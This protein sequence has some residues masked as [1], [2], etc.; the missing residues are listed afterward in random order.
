MNAKTKIVV[1]YMYLSLGVIGHWTLLY[2]WANNKY[3]SWPKKHC[4]TIS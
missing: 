1:A 4:T 2:F 3:F